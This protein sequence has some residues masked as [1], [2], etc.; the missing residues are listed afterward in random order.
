MTCILAYKINGNIC[1]AG[2]SIASNGNTYSIIKNPKI[3]KKGQMLIGYSSSFR[4]G[5]LIQYSFVP[6][7][8]THNDALIYLVEDFIPALRNCLKEGGYTVV[9]NNAETG[10]FFLVGYK[11]RL[12]T[13]QSDFQVSED[14]GNYAALGAGEDFALASM[15]TLENNFCITENNIEKFL[16]DALKAAENFS[17]YVKPPYYVIW[18]KEN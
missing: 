13:V 9:S 6:P 7:E 14:L 11:G 18:E 5:Q 4:M 2:D 8:D 15:Y 3:F 12:F 10:G 17:P 1:M 16:Q